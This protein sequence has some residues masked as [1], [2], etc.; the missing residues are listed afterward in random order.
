MWPDTLSM[1][2]LTYCNTGKNILYHFA[3]IGCY[4][5]SDSFQNPRRNSDGNH[6]RRYVASCQGHGAHDRVLSNRNAR[7]DNRVRAD[8]AVSL[9]RHRPALMVNP[10]NFVDGAIRP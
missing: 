10:V 1:Y 4:E 8:P 6:V 2:R 7:Q 9:E 3:D 5:G